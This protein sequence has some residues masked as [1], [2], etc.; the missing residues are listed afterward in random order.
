MLFCLSPSSFDLC[1]AIYRARG[2]SREIIQN[3]YAVCSIKYS[4]GYLF[5]FNHYLL[6]SS[7]RPKT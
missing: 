4:R 1:G 7:L 3:L 5:K 2:E 6:L